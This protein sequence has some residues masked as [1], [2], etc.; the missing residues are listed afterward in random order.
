M[1]E[2]SE[3]TK[4]VLARMSSNP[5]EFEPNA[6][7]DNLVRGLEEYARGDT[8]GRYVKTLWALEPIEIDV[9]LDKY[10][11]MYLDRLHKQMLKNIVS[12]NDLGP[13]IEQTYQAGIGKQGSQGA[14]RGTS[15][16]TLVTDHIYDANRYAF[17]NGASITA[18]VT[19]TSTLTLG[20]TS[21]TENDV[22]KLK[23]ILVTPSDHVIAKKMGM[24]VQEYIKRRDAA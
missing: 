12:G 2:Y 21:L 4:L 6:R 3:F 19:P 10:R 9:L 13:T 7:W 5:D 17:S 22:K 14:L 8:E 16:S 20:D 18:S 23:K 1:S 15:P 11:R 24:T